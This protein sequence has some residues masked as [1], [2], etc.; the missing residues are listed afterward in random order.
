MR[1]VDRKTF[2]AI[3]H[4]VL[5][6]KIWKERTDDFIFIK[7]GNS[8]DNDFIVLSLIPESL[9]AHNCSND[10]FNK[11]ESLRKD[12]NLSLPTEFDGTGRDGSFDGDE[13]RFMIFEPADVDG[14]I[15]RLVE[16][17]Q[18]MKKAGMV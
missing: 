7:T 17:R 1:I 15:M 6:T 10:L 11:V 2:L 5:F 4:E 16:V 18:D 3:E 14:L 12:P 13:V 9:I 8:G